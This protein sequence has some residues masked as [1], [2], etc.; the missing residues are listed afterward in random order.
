MLSGDGNPGCIL[1][2]KPGNY[3]MH[4]SSWDASGPLPGPGRSA[5]AVAFVLLSKRCPLGEEAPCLTLLMAALGRAQQEVTRDE[6]LLTAQLGWQSII[7]G[8]HS[9]WGRCCTS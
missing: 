9:N 6:A 4:L 8:R 5:Q 7:E 3:S 2:R 1:S